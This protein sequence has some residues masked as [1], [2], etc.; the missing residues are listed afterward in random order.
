MVCNGKYP[1]T[2]SARQRQT[3]DLNRKSNTSQPMVQRAIRQTPT[4]IPSADSA[5]E[6][7]G[8]ET[9]NSNGDRNQMVAI[10]INIYFVYW[11][12]SFHLQM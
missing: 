8:D 4:V 6:K 7:Q 11:E 5:E 2:N 3:S 1:V 10:I 9:L 12:L